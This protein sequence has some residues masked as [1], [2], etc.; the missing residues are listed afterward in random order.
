MFA[1][2]ANVRFA[3]M[4]SQQGRAQGAKIVTRN[5]VEFEG[6]GLSLIDP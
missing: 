2:A 4:G 6:C 3:V 1:V 5:R